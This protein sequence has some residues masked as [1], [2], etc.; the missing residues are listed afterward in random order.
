MYYPHALGNDIYLQKKY[1]YPMY[2]YFTNIDMDIS[3]KSDN[4]PINS[5][6]NINEDYNY[7]NL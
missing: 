6:R 2:I 5:K 1:E 3:V 7:Y 4:T